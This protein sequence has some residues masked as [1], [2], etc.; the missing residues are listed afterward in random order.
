MVVTTPMENPAE[1]M[2]LSVTGMLASM[3]S[4]RFK[5]TMR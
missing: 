5:V 3:I 2:L 4:Q 1:V